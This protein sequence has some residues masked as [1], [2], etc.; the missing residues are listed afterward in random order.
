MISKGLKFEQSGTHLGSRSGQYL[1]VSHGMTHSAS[2][3]PGCGGGEED[4]SPM[5]ESRVISFYFMEVNSKNRLPA[6]GN[7]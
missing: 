5:R 4:N 7:D 6:N 3:Y 2:L 1:L